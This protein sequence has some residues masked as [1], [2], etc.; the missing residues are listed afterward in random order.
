MDM[1]N[2]LKQN[3][4]RPTMNNGLLVGIL[5]GVVLIAAAVGVLMMQPSMEEQKAAVLADAVHEGDPQF[6]D[7]TNDIV[8]ETGENTVESPNAFGSIS[9]Y[10]VGN[11]KNK[12]ERV[13]NGLSV[14]AAVL[15]QQNNV[16]KDKDVLVVPTQRGSISPGEVIPIT[17]EIAGFKR[18]DDRANIRWKVTA[19]RL[20][21]N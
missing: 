1:E 12:G 11:V 10:I 2:L 20:P 5:I 17:L 19:I 16:L 4:R 14:N 9:M 21:Q 18:T 6:V 15:D 7:L 3:D 8:I 13:Y